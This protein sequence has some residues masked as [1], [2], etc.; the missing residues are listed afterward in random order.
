MIDF[1]KVFLK[2]FLLLQFILLL[3]AVIELLLLI[4]QVD[5]TTLDKGIGYIAGGH[6][7]DIA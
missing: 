4:I 5:F 7:Q 2:S 6:V 3:K 1:K